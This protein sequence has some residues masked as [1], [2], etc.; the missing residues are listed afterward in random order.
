MGVAAGD[1]KSA[2]KSSPQISRLFGLI[3]IRQ[4]LG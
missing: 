3:L 1:S 2:A 4:Y